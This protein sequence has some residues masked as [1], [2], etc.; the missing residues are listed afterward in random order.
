MDEHEEPVTLPKH[1][2]GAAR[3]TEREAVRHRLGEPVE[4]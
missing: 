2:S 1:A 4:Q 3:T